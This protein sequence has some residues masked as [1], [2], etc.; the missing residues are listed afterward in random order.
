VEV[1][2]SAC[3]WVL[4]SAFFLFILLL[5]WLNHIS[6]HMNADKIGEVSIHYLPVKKL[7]SQI[8]V[9]L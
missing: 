5:P 4:E 9:I 1:K 3:L 2:V 6:H 7:E 8:R